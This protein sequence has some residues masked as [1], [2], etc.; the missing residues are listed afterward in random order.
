MAKDVA[1]R[2]TDIASTENILGDVPQK[3]SK[4][5]AIAVS[6]NADYDPRIQLFG[7]N[8]KECKAGNINIAHW[9][10]VHEDELVDLGKEAEVLVVCWR[11]KAMRI[12]ENTVNSFFE[13]E[14]PAF[15]SIMEESK[16]KDSGCMYGPEFLVWLPTQ[17]KFVTL[18]LG[19]KTARRASKKL[20]S[21][22]NADTPTVKLSSTLI[23]Q[24]KNSWHGPVF[25]VVTT[26]LTPLPSRQV[27][28][29]KATSF[30]DPPKD[31]VEEA[32]SGR[33]R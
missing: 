11:P 33:E 26:P 1:K 22:L 32:T 20:L 19:S 31:N 13:R 3:Y 25:S 4:E 12:A 15:Q 10:M 8:S 30:L 6:T 18:F 17:E 21:F 7:S 9:G 16:V 2:N 5:D 24:G 14:S 28:G 27:I 29:E 23:E